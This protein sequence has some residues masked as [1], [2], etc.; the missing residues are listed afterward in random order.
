MRNRFRREDISNL[1]LNAFT[2]NTRITPTSGTT[3][4]F[5]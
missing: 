3:I 4:S 5:I 1:T 2:V